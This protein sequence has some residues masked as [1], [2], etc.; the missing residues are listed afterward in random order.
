MHD[1]R[2]QLLNVFRWACLGGRVQRSGCYTGLNVLPQSRL[3][4]SH[5]RWMCRALIVFLL[6][7]LVSTCLTV[8][9]CQST[10]CCLVHACTAMSFFTSCLFTAPL[11]YYLSSSPV[12]F[13]FLQCRHS[14]I[15][16]MVPGTWLLSSSTLVGGLLFAPR[17]P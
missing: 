4:V 8:A 1:V 17:L 16:R 11:C 14:R 15:R 3:E 9:A 10:L 13:L 2:M 7:W 5:C 12:F 6:K